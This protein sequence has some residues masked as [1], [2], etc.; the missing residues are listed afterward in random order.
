MHPRSGQSLIDVLIA[1]A[2]GAILLVGALSVL[3]PALRGGSDAQKALDGAS[4]ARGLLDGVRSLAQSNWNAVA[5]LTAGSPYYLQQTATG[6]NVIAGTE[7]GDVS[8][9]LVARWTFDDASSQIAA[10]AVSGGAP[11]LGTGTTATTSCVS[12]GCWHFNGS[13]FATSTA[14]P[15]L[16]AVQTK[17]FWV[18]PTGDGYVV[19]EGGNNNWVQVYSGKIRAGSN[20]GGGYWDSSTTISYGTWYHV[21]VTQDASN[22]LRIYVNGQLDTTQTM[23]ATNAPGAIRI[24]GYSGGGYAL[25]GIVDDLRIYNRAL[26][27]DEVQKLYLNTVTPISRSFAVYPVRRSAAGIYVDSGGY[28]DSSTLRVVVTYSAPNATS[29]TLGSFLSRSGGKGTTQTDWSAGAIGITTVTD[30]NPAFASSTAI[31]ATSTTGSVTADLLNLITSGGSGTGDISSTTADHF[32]WNDAIGWINFYSS[33]NVQLTSSRLKGYANSSAGEISFDCAT[34]PSGNV[35]GSSSYYVSNDGSGTLMGYAWNDTYGWI[36]LNCANHGGCG[37]SSYS[38][39]VNPSTG[40]FNGFAWNDI[41]GWISFNGA[42]IGVPTYRVVTS[43]RAVAGYGVLD[44]S[45][46][47]TGSANGAQINGVSW[48]GTEPVD[49][50]VRIQL[51]SS[52]SSGGPW[53]FVGSDGT[54][55]SYFALGAGVSSP[56]YPWVVPAQRYFRYRLQLVS[57]Q[58][59]TLAPR[60]DDVVIRWS[61]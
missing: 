61:P 20:A 27:A 21:A 26:A 30:P 53:T 49:T 39:T 40:V 57:N 52:N 12:A 1:S 10:N 45:V 35:C 32:A 44:S 46:I 59:Q 51:A 18:R 25:T 31:D 9:G 16:T 50:D 15:G 60:V 38:V 19:D 54:G 47:D 14:V 36:S 22:V 56:V 4:A 41:I 24:G 6:T 13:G 28:V 29:R 11:A 55:S 33:G 7:S 8:A 2:I 3:A 37:V 17:A 5:S 42:D 34:S 48:S 43:W 23:T 58:A